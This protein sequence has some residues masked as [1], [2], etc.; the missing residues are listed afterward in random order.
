MQALME[1]GLLC[2]DSALTQENGV[3]TP[4]GAPTEVALITAAL[5]AGLVLDNLKAA[6]P[7]VHSVPFESE[8]KFMV[9]AVA[10]GRREMFTQRGAPARAARAAA[11]AGWHCC[12]R[13]WRQG[14]NA[15]TERTDCGQAHRADAHTPPVRAAP[16]PPQA[17]VHAVGPQAGPSTP[18]R[19]IIFVKGAPDRLFPMCSSQLANDEVGTVSGT[20][21][22]APLR[23]EYWLKAQE[24]LSSQGLRVLALCRCARRRTRAGSMLAAAGGGRLHLRACVL[25]HPCKPTTVPPNQCKRTQG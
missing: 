3:W 17:T 5:K 11:A 12:V 16:A 14:C 19:R 13:Q 10:D 2:N 6:K 15:C 22:T 8:H 23:L 4:N 25:E 1:G 7:R 21:G 9:R 20:T 18:G 24:E